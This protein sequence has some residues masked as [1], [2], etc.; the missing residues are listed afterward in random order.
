M[1]LLSRTTSKKWQIAFGPALLMLALLIFVS[2]VAAQT[3]TPRPG[4]TTS[5]QQVSD[6]PDDIVK[7]LGSKG[8]YVS[9]AVKT[10]VNEPGLESKIA[11]TVSKLKGKQDTRIAVLGNT[12]LTQAP[13]S[14]GGNPADY[15]GFLQGYLS[16]PK[17]DVVVVVDANK[18]AVGL[19]TDKLSA[20]ERQEVINESLS[21]FNTKGFGEG[22]SMVAQKAADKISSKETSGTLTTVAI[23]VAI[24]ALIGGFL[25]YRYFTARSYWNKRVAELQGLAG[26]V[27]NMVLD[28]SPKID[29]LSDRVREQARGLF[30]QASSTFSNANTSLRQLEK[31]NTWALMFKGGEYE[32]QYQMTASQ[33]QTTRNALTQVQT[34]VDKDS[35]L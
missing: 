13:Q 1:R 22:A 8:Y 12:I 23:V 5:A 30:G 19:G 35:S 32:K 24:L 15:A 4:G 6:T 20:A 2:P 29:Y 26:Q 31:P 16:S 25:A 33:L 11:D 9:Q 3:A 34:T 18:K 27:S 14:K 7:N 21:T 28:L 10:N 17:P